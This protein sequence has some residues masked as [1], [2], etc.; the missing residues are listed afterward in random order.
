MLLI[1]SLLKS[2]NFIKF[3]MTKYLIGL[4]LDSIVSIVMFMIDFMIEQL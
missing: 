2:F 1:D 3:F 4:G